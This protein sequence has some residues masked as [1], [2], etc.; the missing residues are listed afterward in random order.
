MIG[1]LG[2]RFALTHFG[3]EK[4]QHGVP[5][6]V[7]LQV[8]RKRDPFPRPRKIN[9][10]YFTDGGGGPVGHHDDS[11][12]QQDRFIDIVGDHDDGIAQGR[13][14]LHERVL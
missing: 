11:I 7:V 1:G 12:G 5:I 2:V 13:L 4:M 9:A 8:I 6:V 3:I 10:Q 14:D